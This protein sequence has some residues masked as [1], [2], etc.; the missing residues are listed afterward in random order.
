M[1]IQL[2]NCC[3]ITSYNK[4]F[5]KSGADASNFNIKSLINFSYGLTDSNPLCGAA[6]KSYRKLNFGSYI[7]FT[8][9]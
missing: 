4:A 7:K 2:L 1:Q 5:G 6:Q 3:K 8:F 9:L